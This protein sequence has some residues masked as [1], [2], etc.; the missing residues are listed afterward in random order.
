MIARIALS[1]RH[2]VPQ[3][4]RARHL[5]VQCDRLGVRPLRHHA[6]MS[7]AAEHLGDHVVSAR[8]IS[9]PLASSKVR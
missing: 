2:L 4:D 7:A 5:V 6:V 9:L 1:A 8:N 3:P